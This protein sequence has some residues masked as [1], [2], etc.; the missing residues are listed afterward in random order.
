MFIAVNPEDMNIWFR[1]LHGSLTTAI[2]P[3][4]FYAAANFDTAAE[5]SAY[6]QYIMLG[7]L[8]YVHQIFNGIA[9]DNAVNYD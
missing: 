4:I 6:L 3:D 5:F 2:Y 7:R 9:S 1:S 8:F